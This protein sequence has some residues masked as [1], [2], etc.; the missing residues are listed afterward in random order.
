M[1]E[2]T[3]ETYLVD[4][5]RKNNYLCYK[6]VSPSQNGVPDRIIIGNGFTIF[7]ELKRPSKNQLDPLQEVICQKMRD[8]GAIVIMINTKDKVDLL[9]KLIKNKSKKLNNKIKT[10]KEGS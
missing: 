1:I 3:V 5:C 9:I 6:F 8:S 7:I 4:Q 2:N 10:I